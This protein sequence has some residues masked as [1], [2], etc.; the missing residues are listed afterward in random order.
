LHALKKNQDLL[1]KLFDDLGAIEAKLGPLED[2]FKLL[3]EYSINLKEEDILKRNQLK[4]AWTEFC[5]ML[6]RIK[7]RNEKVS[8]ELYHET[9]KG[10]EDFMKE[11]GDNKALFIGNAPYHSREMTSDKAIG[12]LIEYRDSAKQLRKREENMKFGVD[13]FKI[14]Y[15]PSPD[16]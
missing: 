16:L 5:A 15:V 13:L 1:N 2:K 12:I 4:E 10:L 14:A 3:D 11:T 6:E 9:M 8:T 7:K